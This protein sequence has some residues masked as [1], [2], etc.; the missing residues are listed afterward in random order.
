MEVK[1]ITI[2][3]TGNSLSAE[4]IYNYLKLNGKCSLCHFLV[5]ETR[6]INCHPINKEA[7]HTGK[8]YD[9]GNMHTI[10]I[11]ICRSQS[12]LNLYIRAETRAV[13][14]IKGLMKQYHLNKNCLYFH[15]DF[16]PSCFCP[17]RILEI[18]GNKK[19]FIKER[20]L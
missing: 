10:A 5:D 8:G 16:D 14:L 3:N 17:H 15:R 12:N 19:N 18:Y 7:F 6:V 2:H 13:K 11:E 9:Y 4:D 1:G 20:N